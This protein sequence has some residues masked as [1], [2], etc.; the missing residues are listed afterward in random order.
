MGCGQ[1]PRRA[2]PGQRV[3]Q[4]IGD[5]VASPPAPPPGGLQALRVQSAGSNP[6]R[7]RVRDRA[8]GGDST[9]PVSPPVPRG[10]RRVIWHMPGHPVFGETQ[11]CS[12]DPLNYGLPGR[13]STECRPFPQAARSRRPR[14][15]LFMQAVAGGPSGGGDAQPRAGWTGHNHGACPP[16][17]PASGRAGMRGSPGFSGGVK[18]RLH[19]A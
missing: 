6:R 19:S 10:L 1:P 3:G 4:A 17:C 13:A 14:R 18:Y 2:D 9:A 11:P 5:R 16:P 8:D 7:N 15:T 12:S